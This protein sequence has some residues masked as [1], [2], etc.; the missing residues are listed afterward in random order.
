MKTL[1]LCSVK[2][3]VNCHASEQNI[4]C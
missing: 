3:S 2:R 4:I 1:K